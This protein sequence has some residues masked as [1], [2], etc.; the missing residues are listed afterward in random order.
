M[1]IRPAVTLAPAAKR[2]LSIGVCAVRPPEASQALS[3]A[4]RRLLALLPLHIDER[5]RRLHARRQPPG[6]ASVG[7]R[8]HGV[9]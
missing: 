8:R 7:E 5:R 4:A 9:G 3:A 2:T 6:H 1:A